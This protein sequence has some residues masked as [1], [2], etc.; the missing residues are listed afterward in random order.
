MAQSNT[1]Q[2]SG[3]T[4]KPLSVYNADGQYIRTYSLERH[5]KDYREKAEG[6]LKSNPKARGG[7]IQEGEASKTIVE[8]TKQEI[9]DIRARARASESPREK[10]ALDR[11]I[12]NK[13]HIL[14]EMEASK[15][16][17]KKK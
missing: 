7:K 2:T 8:K 11:E 17:G 4:K 15:T 9:A 3:N 13:L 12:H 6:F 1:T 10:D 16:S 5:G 14:Q